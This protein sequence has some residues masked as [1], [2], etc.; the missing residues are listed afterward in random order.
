ME[1]NYKISFNEQS[2]NSIKLN[3]KF[4]LQKI[5]MNS[6]KIREIFSEDEISEFNV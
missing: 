6:W 4:L 5:K 2:F 1:K 3:K